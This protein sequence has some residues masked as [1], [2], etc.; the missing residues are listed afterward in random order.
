MCKISKIIL[1]H[2]SYDISTIINVRNMK[3]HTLLH[4]C[5]IQRCVKFHAPNMFCRNR[6]IVCIGSVREKNEG[7]ISMCKI[8]KIILLHTSYDISTTKDVRNMKFHTLLYQFLNQQWI[9]FH[10]RNIFSCNLIIVCMGAVREKNEGSISICKISKIILL[11]IY[12]M[13]YQQPTTFE[14]WNFTHYCINIYCNSVSN[15]MLQICA[16]VI[17][18]LFVWAQ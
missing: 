18:S 2:T 5:F 14:K 15:F 3:F 16:V 9:K 17:I 1:P 7:S 13:I 4:H 12:H 6:I 8:S 10:A 11:P